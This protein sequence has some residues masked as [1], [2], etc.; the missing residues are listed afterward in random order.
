MKEVVDTGLHVSGGT[1]SVTVTVSTESGILDGTATNDK[2]Q[3]IANAVVVAIPAP[4][5]RKQSDRYVRTTTDQAGHFT[6]R[7]VRPGEY[8]VLAW[9]VLD[10][11]DYLDPDFLNP[12]EAQATSVKI[13][14]T[15]HQ[16]VTLKVIPA[17]ADQP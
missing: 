2:G 9:E 17:P 1:L 13:E 8:S 7:G 15:G 3:A 10:G 16:T 12:L 4:Q 5:F 11:D 14:K 6:M